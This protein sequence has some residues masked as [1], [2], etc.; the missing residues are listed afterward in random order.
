VIFMPKLVARFGKKQTA[1]LG[2]GIC[3]A[4]DL[5]NFFIPTNI[6]SFTILSAIAFIGISIPNGITWAL[7]SDIIDYGEWV[8]G[9][10]KEATT[11]SLF[12]FSR[13]LAQ[14]LAGF[15]SGISLTLV[16]YV[17]NVAQSAGTLLGIKGMLTLY[18][19]AALTIAVLIIG[20]MYKL[21]DEKHAQI[22]KDLEAKI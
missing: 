4:A 20:F 8:S 19:A 15:L 10:R 14:S 21:T 17:P 13:K 18:P 2:F 16:G 3:I 9:E 5:L 22:I 7:V 11:Y 1:M 6:Y 12:N